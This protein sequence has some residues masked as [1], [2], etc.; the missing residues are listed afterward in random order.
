VTIA[1]LLQDLRFAARMLVKH[2]GFTLIAIITLGVG[3]G[4]NVALFSVINAVLLQPLPYGQP[5]QLVKIWEKRAR[6]PK[7]RVSWADYVDWKV[8]SHAFDGTAAYRTGDYNLTGNGDDPEQVQGASVSTS[9]FP[10]LR[11]S[12]QLGRSFSADDEKPGA[13]QVVILSHGLWERRFGG[14]P[15][16]LGKSIRI[17]DA[18]FAVVGI[19]PPGFFFPNHEIELWEPFAID[20][21]SRMAGRSM[22]ILDVIGRLRP[23]VR[24]EQARAEM[25]MIAAHLEQAY[26]RENTGHGADV[27]LLLDDW[28]SSYRTSLILIFG[29]VIFVLLIA[30]ANVAT[31]LLSRAA[32][33]RREVAIRCALGAGRER[34]VCQLLVESLLL[35]LMG[36]VA[37]LLLAHWLIKAIILVTPADISRIGES[38]LNLPVLA[39]ALLVALGSGI[40]SGLAP[41][42]HLSNPDTAG[43]LKESSRGATAST[44]VSR[45]RNVFVVVEVALSAILLTGA[46]LLLKSFLLVEHVSPGFNVANVLTANVSLQNANYRPAQRQVFIAQVLDRIRTD[47]GVLAVGA[48]THLPLAGNGPSFDFEVAGRPAA[49]PGE[50]SK[51]QIRCATPDY[52]R[53]LGI[54]LLV[55]RAL[56]A[57]DSAD[58]PDVIVIN[59]VMAQRYWPNESPLGK[60]LSFDQTGGGA[61]V[62]RE[63]VGVVQGVRHS[64]LESEPEPQMYAPFSQFSMPFA[65][66]VVRT[67]GEPLAFSKALRRA[68]ASVDPTEPVSGIKSMEQ[69]LEQSIASRKFNALMVGF[70]AAIAMLA[71][72]IGVYGVLSYA[73][74]QRRPEIGIRLALGAGARTV[75]WLVIKDGMSLAVYGVCLGAV[76]ASVVTRLLSTLLYKV[77]VTDPFVF[78]SIAALLLGVALLASYLPAYRATKVDPVVALRSE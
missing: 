75:M 67:Y 8:Q 3:I 73:V 49:A 41:A 12:P 11:V 64:G 28:T 48:V 31:L 20:P 72:S 22:H 14:D 26:P 33:R 18:P 57:A 43:A 69:V 1:S 9:L 53:A 54:S 46:G 61:P 58:A 21:N 71:A 7:G 76:G 29:A 5:D 19:M 47:P 2:R 25:G 40:L 52:F 35:A 70:F 74:A 24:L 42:L 32:Q 27:F 44:A 56:S 63:I 39:F 37:G 4:A 6:L 30:C 23:G 62:W 78:G 68:V 17:D 38:N 10:L 13:H 66:L 15:G 50:E 34:I 16:L 36:A 45:L 60:K 59:D 77:S 65:T 55:G 51:A